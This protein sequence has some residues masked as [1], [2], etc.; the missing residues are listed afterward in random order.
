MFRFWARRNDGDSSWRKSGDYRELHLALQVGPPMTPDAFLNG[1]LPMFFEFA[2]STSFRGDQIR[3]VEHARHWARRVGD[4][5]RRASEA[6]AF[7]DAASAMAREAFEAYPWLVEAFE[8]RRG[9]HG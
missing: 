4:N 5:A 8:G 2:T 9:H 3:T 7:Q 6:A 1:P